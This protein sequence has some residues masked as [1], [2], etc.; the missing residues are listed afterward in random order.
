MI[1][2]GKR[3]VLI[4]LAA[5]PFLHA[6]VPI[7][8]KFYEYY[9]VASTTG[10]QFSALGAPSINDYGLLAFMG[11]TSIGQTIWT[12]DGNSHALVDINPGS[13]NPGTVTFDPQM[14]INTNNTVIAR[15]EISGTSSNIRIW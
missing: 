7:P 12:G 4:G 6:Q 10:G 15:D 3:A 1:P 11:Q 9:L 13:G 2:A 14:Q 8:G 5:L